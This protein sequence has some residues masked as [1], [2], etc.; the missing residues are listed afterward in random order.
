LEPIK[1]CETKREQQLY[2]RIYFPNSIRI[3]GVALQI[4]ACFT[5]KFFFKK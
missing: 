1:K 2:H 5:P 4:T 3:Y